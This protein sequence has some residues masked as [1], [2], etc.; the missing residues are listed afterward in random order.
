MAAMAVAF[1][2]ERAHTH[3]RTHT[4]AQVAQSYT[5][6]RSYALVRCSSVEQRAVRTTHAHAHVGSGSG[7]GSSGGGG[8]RDDDDDNNNKTPEPI[9]ERAIYTHLAKTDGVSTAE[10]I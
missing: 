1:A 6:R 8:G 9:P 10:G 3:T 2:V 5:Q 7:S 4:L